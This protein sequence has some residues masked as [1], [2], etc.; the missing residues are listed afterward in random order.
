MRV[1]QLVAMVFCTCI[2]SACSTTKPACAVG[3]DLGC[4]SVMDVN[5]AINEGYG[6]DVQIA[7]SGKPERLALA[8]MSTYDDVTPER[9]QEQWVKVWVP[10]RIDENDNYHPAT[11]Y[12]TVIKAAHWHEPYVD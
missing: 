10:S 9:T 3:N 2:L 8:P 6:S 12:Y 5:Q 4:Q 1:I 7:S 11:E